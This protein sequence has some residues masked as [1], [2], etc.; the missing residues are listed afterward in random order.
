MTSYLVQPIL[1]PRI[2]QP[3]NVGQV[4]SVGAAVTGTRLRQSSPDMPM[5][6]YA[7]T[8][9]GNQAR[10][11]SYV[12]TLPLITE[13]SAYTTA[14][15]PSKVGYRFQNVRG[16]L[17]E[18]DLAGRATIAK[19]KGENFIP[20]GLLTQVNLPITSLPLVAGF[21]TGLPATVFGRSFDPR[22]QSWNRKLKK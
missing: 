4:G 21:N 22:R 15:K 1:D 17:T 7:A 10:T 13:D 16:G 8:A 18:T 3:I 19:V 11:G 20:D 14:V 5:R 2:I 6:Y 9:Y 12:G